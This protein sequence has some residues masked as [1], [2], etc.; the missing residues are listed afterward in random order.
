MATQTASRPTRSAQPPA[1]SNVVR[2]S[3]GSIVTKG[4]GLPNRYV[5]YAVEGWGK[6]SLAAHY[7]KPIFIQSRGETG[8]ETLIDAGQLPETPH[9]PECHTWNDLMGCV[10]TLLEDEHQFKT[11]VIDT[12]NGAERLCHEEVCARDFNNDWGERGFMSYQKGPEL[13]LTDWR[14]LLGKLDRLRLEKGM[15]IVL[16]AHAKVATFK[17]PEGPDFDRHSPDI[18]KR[19]WSLTHKWAD[20]VLFGKY[21]VIVSGGTTGEKARKGKGVGQARMM[22]TQWSAAYDA[23][24]RLGLPPEIEMGDTPVDAWKNFRAAVVAGRAALQQQKPEQNGGQE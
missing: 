3:L 12:I 8:L 18:D 6:T 10:D 9:F 7:P 16:L 15:T 20:C 23:K 5:T 1:P 21:E 4:N 11:V 19:T 14:V 2:M 13:A 22:F 24:N 17:N